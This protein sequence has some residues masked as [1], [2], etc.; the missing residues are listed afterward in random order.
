MKLYDYF[1]IIG[2]A[3]IVIW[4]FAALVILPAWIKRSMVL[5]ALSVL[6]AF[7][8]LG[9]ARVN[10]Q[11]VSSIQ[12]DR[13]E[14]LRQAMERQRAL[15]GNVSLLPASRQ[16]FVEEGTEEMAAT[17]LASNRSIYEQAAAGDDVPAYLRRGRQQRSDA[18]QPI[19]ADG[20]A[21]TVKPPRI[22]SQAAVIEANQWDRMNLLAARSMVW[23]SLIAMVL[24]YLRLFND[25]KPPKPSLPLSSPL[26]DLFS[27]KP[28]HLE[29]ELSTPEA[30]ANYLRR[31]ARR[32][33]SFICF[34]DL[35]L[36]LPVAL[37][38][39][40][41]GRWNL[42]ALPVATDPSIATDR[43]VEY[44]FESVWFNRL[45][46]VFSSLEATTYLIEYFNYLLYSRI[47]SRASAWQTMVIL[48][49]KKAIEGANGLETL[50]FF[51]EQTNI[52]LVFYSLGEDV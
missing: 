25:R 40:G 51:A 9:L 31:T 12:V 18:G 46:V 24:L 13:S 2:I 45:G 37:P 36:N 20:E 7:S 11:A 44:I 14:I 39:I 52:Q 35:K 16:R 3:S 4:A 23:L 43:D 38:R 32:G 21:E 22:M 50:R 19:L 15:A 49:P 33:E 6:F 41:L 27:R 29:I 30:L 17:M 48:I 47:R 1:G 42:S 10:S 28:N 5:A 34:A 26:M 8:G